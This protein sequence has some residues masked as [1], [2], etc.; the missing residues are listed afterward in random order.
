MSKEWIE[1]KLK[2]MTLEEKLGQLVMVSCFDLSDERFPAYLE[3]LDKYPMGG[4]F[5]FVGT[6][7]HL[8]KRIAQ[9]QEGRKIPLLMG[10]D[11]EN[12][13]GYIVK[14][15]T[16]FPRQMARGWSG[17]EKSEYQIGKI[18]A[19]QGRAIG[20]H[21]TMSPVVDVNDDFRCPDVN[22]RAYCDDSETICRLSVPYI[23]GLQENGMLSGAKHFPGNGGTGMDQHIA[24]SIVLESRD[25]L[26]NRLAP[27]RLAIKQADLAAVM[28]GHLEIPAL[29]TE[30][31]EKTGRLVPTTLSSEVLQD[32]LRDELGFKGLIITDAMDMGGVTN[33]FTRE[34]AAVKA[35]N[36]GV[37]ML[38]I[39]SGNNWE[40]EYLALVEAAKAG[41]LREEQV[42][43]AVRQVLATKVR[44]GLH[45]DDG[46]PASDE[47]RAELYTV[48][49]D[50]AFCRELA[51][52][53][54]TVLWNRGGI[55]PLADVKGKRLLMINSYSPER[56]TMELH[57]QNVP[58]IKLDEM[59]EERGAKLD[60]FEI[61]NETSHE[62]LGKL[63][64]CLAA[65]DCVFYNF[66]GI[67]SWG[68]GTM[69]PNRGAV[70]LFY[71]GIFNQGKPVVVSAFGDPWV[72]YYC[73]SAPAY[74]ATFDEGLF[75][76]Q[77]AVK[78]WTGEAK[79][80]G[81]MPVSLPGIFKRGDGIDV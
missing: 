46:A 74:L 68:I 45:E 42:D 64:E 4:V 81:R 6:Q 48:G 39:F 12:G 22:I 17:D 21:I 19:E 78:V 11:Y 62:E 1:A 54:V 27:Y 16:R 51:A 77:A 73:P 69:I 56:K 13:A 35:I 43:R 23:K 36:A 33:Q 52:K 7:Q 72:A 38:L 70:G 9:L 57:G 79:A 55:L 61:T 30:L 20:M 14:G 65:C 71:H 25:Q 44:A 59:L 24:A 47:K 50:D 60:L 66:I 32:L 63:N 5:V 34:Q 49:R 37:D 80:T 67:P 29:T 8:A 40:K 15:G 58:E 76:Q 2:E 53:A 41:E 18:T 3:K 28:V 31:A 26:E 10:C 75:S